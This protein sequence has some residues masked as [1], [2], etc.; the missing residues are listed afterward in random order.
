VIKTLATYKTVHE[1]ALSPHYPQLECDICDSTDI[2]ETRE[3]YVCI[4][5]GIVLEI[6]KLQYDRPYNEDLIQYM[7]GLGTTQVGTKRE[8]GISPN[9]MKLHR[10]NKHNS[11]T[12]NEKAV[13][14]KARAEILRILG[15]LKLNNYNSVKK[16]AMKKFKMVRAEFR[17][18]SK[19]RNIEKLS[20]IIIYYCLKLQN[21]PVNTYELIEVS[22]ISK[23]EFNDFNLQVRRY[24]PEYAERNRQKYIIQRILEVVEHFELGMPFYHL[25]KK[26]LYR[27]WN[28]IKNTTDN[29]VAGLVSSISVLCSCKDKVSVSA[30]CSR[31]GIR[32]STVQVQVRKKIFKRFKVEGFISLIKSSDLLIKI[33]EKLGLLKDEGEAQEEVMTD[34]HVEIVLGNVAKVFNNHDNCDYYYFAVRGEVYTPSIITVKINESPLNFESYKRQ[35]E[36]QINNMLDFDIYKY[37]RSKGPP[38]LEA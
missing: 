29:A 5:C 19:Y 18:G 34:G 14:E 2:I 38:L 30:I 31:L 17:P 35:K 15:Y 36:L 32:M 9:S 11:I 3:G 8:R 6:Q 12:D 23:K 1:S 16:I 7:K 10:L 25:A 26:I 20:S 33:M 37:Y 27:L 21:I 22:K 28:G 24:F 4:E 13:V